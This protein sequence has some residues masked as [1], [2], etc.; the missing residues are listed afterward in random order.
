MMRGNDLV[1]TI[2]CWLSRG[3]MDQQ[4]PLRSNCRTLPSRKYPHSRHKV[5]L[6]TLR[7]R[8]GGVRLGL[9]EHHKQCALGRQL[10]STGNIGGGHRACSR[11]PLGLRVNAVTTNLEI[12]AKRVLS[13]AV[14]SYVKG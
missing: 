7:H 10:A 2:C 11:L 3:K 13:P 1:P 9:T 12:Q 5:T 8:A 4:R 14:L 6:F